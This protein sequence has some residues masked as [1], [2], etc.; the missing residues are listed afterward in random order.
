MSDRFIERPRSFC[1]LGGAL[2]TALALPDTVPIL[3]ASMG[4]GG[5][6][7]STLV[8]SPGMFLARRTK[9]RPLCGWDSRLKQS[10]TL[11]LK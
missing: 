9:N 3:H 10:N 6:I 7:Y 8:S 5:S 4:C 2:H 11:L 1:A